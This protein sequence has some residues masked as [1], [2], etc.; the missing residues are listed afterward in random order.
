MWVIDGST[1]EGKDP[2]DGFSYH[3]TYAWI[4]QWSDR[5]HQ[6]SHRI[7]HMY[8]AGTCRMMFTDWNSSHFVWNSSGRIRSRGL[9]TIWL[10]PEGRCSLTG[11]ATFWLWTAGGGASVTG[12]AT[13]SRSVTKA[14]VGSG[15]PPFQ[16]RLSPNPAIWNLHKN[17]HFFSCTN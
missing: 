3:H 17:H 4:H 6:W 5:I 8:T 1:S 14:A 9:S 10:E 12:T 7:R 11:T 13:F 15:G 16:C 2:T